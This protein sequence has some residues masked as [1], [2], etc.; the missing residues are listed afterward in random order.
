MKNRK[1]Y[2]IT[3]ACVA[4]RRT[5]FGDTHTMLAA[6]RLGILRIANRCFLRAMKA[7]PSRQAVAPSI[8]LILYTGTFQYIEEPH[9]D[10]RLRKII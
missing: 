2:L 6:K 7:E 1:A 9:T 4:Q 8:K 5:A 10:A 3:N